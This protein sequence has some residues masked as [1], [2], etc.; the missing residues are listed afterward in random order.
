MAHNQAKAE[1]SF[2]HALRHLSSH[3]RREMRLWRGWLP[4]A[5]AREASEQE[6]LRFGALVSGLTSEWNEKHDPA[7]TLKW[8]SLFNRCDGA[9]A[10]LQADCAR[11]RAAIPISRGHRAV[12]RLSISAHNVCDCSYLNAK[13]DYKSEDLNQAATTLLD[14]I[15]NC[16]HNS[17]AQV[18]PPTCR[19]SESK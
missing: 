19:L 18:T 3:G 17:A 11:F 2:D 14:I 6:P 4:D 13:E 10:C 8:L 5:V 12:L 15:L 1:T 9:R 7:L 16:Q